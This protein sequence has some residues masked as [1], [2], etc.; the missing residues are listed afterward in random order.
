MIAT[1]PA[2]PRGGLA[3]LR[4]S[5]LWG[6]AL[7]VFFRACIVFFAVDSI[8][9][10]SDERYAGKGL[11]I[12]NVVI[13]LVWSMVFPALYRIWKK[14][15]RYPVA[16]DNLYLSVFWL[17]MFGN[18]LD[19]YNVVPGWDTLPHFHGPGALTLIFRGL[20]RRSI[21]ASTG[22]ANMVH[23]A[24]EIQEF[25]GDML[26]GTHNV[27]GEADTIHDLAAGLLGSWAYVGGWELFHRWRGIKRLPD[28]A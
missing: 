21:L 8:I 14:W 17:D 23:V 9:N 2:S 5:R 3:N 15:D 20:G 7:N 27:E 11:P 25:L 10:A 4:S 6:W 24:L 28:L 22:V 13:V 16:W 18:H 26:G 12:R 19:F 1:A